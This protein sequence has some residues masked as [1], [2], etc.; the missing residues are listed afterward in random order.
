MTVA[1]PLGAMALI[2][3]ATCLL[4]A[5]TPATIHSLVV[6]Q[7]RT[8]P[9][10]V[11]ERTSIQTVT[12][13]VT[14]DVV[15]GSNST[16]T[17]AVTAH[18]PVWSATHAVGTAIVAQSSLDQSWPS[19]FITLAAGS[20]SLVLLG[21]IRATVQ[22]GLDGHALPSGPFTTSTAC[23][24]EATTSSSGSFQVTT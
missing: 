11:V 19:A 1:T 9:P 8:T 3:F 7:W 16:T 22:C 13:I 18:S 6:T 24:L 14:R 20:Y 23:T 5:T 12:T 17:S 15:L 10:R 4:L 2:L 21:D